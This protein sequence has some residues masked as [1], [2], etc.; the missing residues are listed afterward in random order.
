[1]QG[2][3]YVDEPTAPILLVHFFIF[4]FE[5]WHKEQP[6]TKKRKHPHQ[7]KHHVK[8]YRTYF[9]TCCQTVLNQVDHA[10]QNSLH[11]LKNNKPLL[12]VQIV[13]ILLIHAEIL[14]HPF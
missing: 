9:N 2:P 4:S 1:M 5:T 11:N 7:Q 12:K 14:L 3:F 10:L 6:R 13:L 8:K